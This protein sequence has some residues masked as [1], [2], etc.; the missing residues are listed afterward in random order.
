MMFIRDDIKQFT[1]SLP[2]NVCLVIATKYLDVEEMEQLYKLGYRNF[3]ENRV[4]SFLTKY[5]AL[6]HNDIIWHFIGHLQRNKANKIINNIDYL[7]SLDSLELAKLIDKKRNKPLKTF[8]EVSINEE[9]NKNGVKINDLD[10]FIKQVLNYK[11]IQLV[12]L[13][14]MA[15][16]SSD[17][18]SLRNQFAKLR[19]IRDHLEH[20]FNVNLPY[21]SMGMSDDYKEAILEGATHIRL[22]RILFKE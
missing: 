19:A 7:H 6:N 22:G 8:I 5:N 13:M 16:K 10:D 12:G 15:I 17:E 4:E 20:K 9:Q 18:E 21:L 14:M 3:A 1:S 11:N 2:Q